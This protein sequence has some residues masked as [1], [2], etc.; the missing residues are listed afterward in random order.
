[1]KYLESVSGPVAVRRDCW[2]GPRGDH[3]VVEDSPD[4]SNAKAEDQPLNVEDGPSRKV[5]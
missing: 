5:E 2:R 4:P 1:M 3:Q